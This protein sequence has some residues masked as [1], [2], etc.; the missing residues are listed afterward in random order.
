[1]D[2]SVLAPYAIHADV[3]FQ[4]QKFKPLLDRYDI[5]IRPVPPQRLEKKPIE[6]RHGVIRSTFLRLRHTDPSFSASVLA[7]P[8]V[9]ISND[10]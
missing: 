3:A 9:R 8:A 10:L 7:I 1:M 5:T 2:S 4:S 6:P